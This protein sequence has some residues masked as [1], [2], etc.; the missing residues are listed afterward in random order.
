MRRAAR[1]NGI[2]G[3]GESR[4]IKQSLVK[5]GRFLFLN[6]QYVGVMACDTMPLCIFIPAEMSFCFVMK[7][8]AATAPASHRL[9]ENLCSHQ[10][11]KLLARRNRNGGR[12]KCYRRVR[13]IKPS[14]YVANGAVRVQSSEIIGASPRKSWRN[15]GAVPRRRIACDDVERWK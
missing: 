4:G 3:Y 7:A 8:S 13:G 11:N 2:G 15:G 5:C 14:S 6:I 12:Q 9:A 1:A 10:R